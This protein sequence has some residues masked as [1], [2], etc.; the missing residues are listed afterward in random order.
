M[1]EYLVE[2]NTKK[3]RYNCNSALPTSCRP[4]VSYY[5]PAQFNGEQGM[6]QI[7][8]ADVDEIIERRFPDLEEMLRISPPILANHIQEVAQ[9]LQIETDRIDLIT[10]WGCHAAI[11]AELRR[12]HPGL[13]MVVN[14]DALW[15][16]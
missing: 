12:L 15:H 10:L 3:T 8:S 9:Q 13:Y 5:N 2:K 7:P 16:A 14:V 4:N 6:T 11:V 1:N